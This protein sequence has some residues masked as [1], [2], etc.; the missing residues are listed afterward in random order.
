M[1]FSPK[2]QR[3]TSMVIILLIITS[4]SFSQKEIE[5]TDFIAP[6]NIP[7]FLSGNFGELRSSHFHTGIDIKT[8]GQ[9]GFEVRSP[10]D[11]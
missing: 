2:Y 4:H 7:L 10:E 3:I 8:Q 9:T 6:L 1:N 5:N 11:G